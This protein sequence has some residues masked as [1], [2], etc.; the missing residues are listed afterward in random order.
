M[1]VTGEAIP[2]TGRRGLHLLEMT[3]ILYLLDSQF[4]EGGEVIRLTRNC[5][6]PPPP[7]GKI[8]LVAE[9]P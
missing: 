6:S 9:S 4:T 8:F 3:R 7:P 2:V 5:A 1:E